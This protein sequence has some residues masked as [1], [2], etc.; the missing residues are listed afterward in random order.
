MGSFSQDR[1]EEKVY[2]TISMLLVSK[3]LYSIPENAFVT[4]RRV[5]LSTD[6]KS[7]TVYFTYLGDEIMGDKV[8]KALSRS[9]GVIQHH[10]SEAM[11]TK[12]TPKLLF[13]ED[14]MFEKA[15]KVDELLKGINKG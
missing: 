9:S 11:R 5:E 12:N 13:K 7:A 14:T 1:L 15:M 3:K 2:K 4:I 8:K 6:N 10:L